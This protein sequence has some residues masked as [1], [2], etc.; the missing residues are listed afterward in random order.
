[1]ALCFLHERG[2][3][4]VNIDATNITSG[5]ATLTLG[6][7]WIIILKF[8][9]VLDVF[10]GGNFF[11]QMCYWFC[12]SVVHVV[13]KENYAII[14]QL[15]RVSINKQYAEVFPIVW[16]LKKLPQALWFHVHSTV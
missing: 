15:T 4:L 8:Q 14:H 9:V 6:M 16:L 7:L 3:Q 10:I 12:G 1:M 5:D 11:N 2:L 13:C